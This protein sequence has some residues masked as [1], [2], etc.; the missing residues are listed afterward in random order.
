MSADGDDPKGS[1]GGA[2]QKRGRLKPNLQA[3]ITQFAQD[4]SL[5][6]SSNEA[7]ERFVTHLVLHDAGYNDVDIE[8]MLSGGSQDNQID[9]LAM[10]LNGAFLASVEDVEAALALRQAGSAHRVEALALQITMANRWE[11]AKL[12]SFAGG[13]TNFFEEAPLAPENERLAAWRVIKDHLLQAIRADSAATEVNLSLILACAS[14]NPPDAAIRGAQENARR[15]V[16]R[17]GLFDKVTLEL[18]DGNRLEELNG[19]WRRSNQGVLKMGGLSAL[20][21]SANIGRA[22]I[23]W[24]KAQDLLAILIGDHGKIRPNVFFENVR[25]YLG[26]DPQKNPVNAEIARSLQGPD[27][28]EFILRNN[29]VSITARAVEPAGDKQLALTGYQVVNGCQTSYTLFEHRDRLTDAATVAVK[30][31]ET[32]ERSTVRDIAAGANNQ[33]AIGEAEFLSQLPFVRKLQNYFSGERMRSPACALWLERRANELAEQ[34]LEKPG[35]VVSI[36]ELIEDYIAAFEQRP[37]LVHDQGWKSMLSRID[38]GDMLTLNDN[39][40][41]Y[42]SCGLLRWR[43]NGFIADFTERRRRENAAAP[44]NRRRK[45]VTYPARHQLTLALRLIAGPSTPLIA[46][47]SFKSEPF[48]IALTRLNEALAKGET[49]QKM[50]EQADAL[51]RE[52]V[53]SLGPTTPFTVESAKKKAVTDYLLNHAPKE[54]A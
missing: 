41:I 52:A 30:I 42:F 15:I 13:A 32:T 17:L 12:Y 39:A 4:Y 3:A 53:Q 28:A 8:Q 25:G 50:L 16:E 1:G 21:P 54:G 46:R 37:H 51:V 18:I 44:A 29:G 6:P 26:G 5:D 11:Q 24:A 45:T 34:R 10:S 43:V 19:R 48:S 9:A 14:E 47:P 33:T 36:L 38:L 49:A 35:Q 7:A 27:Q 23:G 31:I 20:P 40:E 2:L 22:W